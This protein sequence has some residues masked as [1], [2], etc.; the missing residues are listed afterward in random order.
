VT[1]I[2][3]KVL[4][5]LR[6][7]RLQA[8]VIFVTTLLAVITGTMTLTLISQ[9]RD[10]FQAAFE[11]Q[12]GAHLQVAFDSRVDSG[13]IVGSPSLIGAA[14]SG[15]PYHA[16]DME[17]QASGHK[18]LVTTVGRDDPNGAVEQLRI[19]D[20]HWP[21]SGREIALTRSFADLNHI[22]IGDRLKVLS[23][24]K[25]PVLSVAGLV[26]DIDQ[27]RADVGGQPHAWVLDSA[28]APLSLKDASSYRM[29]YRFASDPTGAQLLADMNTLRASL[30]PGSIASSTNYLLIHGVF[31]VSTQ[32]LTSV[33]IAFSVFALAATAAIVAN[34]VTGIVI[35]GYREIGI[36]KAVGFTP[37]QVVGVV[38][39]QILVPS[40]AACVIG[41][42]AGMIL[43]QPLLANSSQALGLAYQ[44]TY[45]P[46]VGLLTLAG[47]LLIVTIAALIP[48]LRA[49]L[50]KPAIVI[51]NATA[52]RGNSGR[53]LRRLA[54]RV[55]LPQPVVLGLGD[56]VSRPARAIL[57]LIAI[58]VGVV[59]IVVA[60]GETRNF[61]GIYKYEAHSGTVDAVVTKSAALSDAE[62][63]QLINSQ[64][65]TA[66]V[67]AQTTANI[68][69]PGIADPVYT[70]IFRGD[71]SAIGYELTAG[72]WMNGPGEAVAPMGLVQ[73]AHLRV[74]DIFTG[75][76][77]GTAVRLRIVGEVYDFIAGPGGHELFLDESTITPVVPP[78]TPS[79]YLV[80]LKPGSNVE[81]YVRRLAATQPDLLDVRAEGTGQTAF[82]A[83]IAGILFGIAAVIALIAIAGI[84]NTTLLN[85]RE[86]VRDTATLRALGMSPRQ[87][88]G[89][90]AASS[91]L[92]ALVGGLVA[93]PAGIEL[94][95]LLF[96]L[97][98]NLGGNGTPAVLYSRFAGWELVA[99]P[100]AGVGVAVA[101]AL[102]PGRWAARTNVVEV[103]RAE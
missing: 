72:R 53:W 3:V 52:P 63:T 70:V 74:G 87:V 68:T 78:L 14:A 89:M 8:V 7:R 5:D 32:V 29:N 22:S 101:A 85:A 91:G 17:F 30:P 16:T 55:R 65:E 82:L 1:A 36:M 103:L 31:N 77:H 41:I 4:A 56:A 33:L 96:D 48:A 90:V 15:G 59:S 99:I 92:L 24:P 67:V 73:D 66:R 97:I 69:V 25:G 6:R 12:K 98:G 2:V 28:I 76:L 44:A 86:G 71:S 11:A 10:S 100:L 62:A 75:T 54:L 80:A 19:T 23:V 93:V 26:V 21:S 18:Y 61:Y 39:L 46:V 27:V 88:I 40:S 50:L 94:S 34:L 38:V 49:G 79:S 37:L 43:G 102:V 9:T 95:R 57:T 58:F 45:S 83:S 20:G 51:A 64:P 81:A 47:A 35:S 42:P 60:L 84:F 13:A